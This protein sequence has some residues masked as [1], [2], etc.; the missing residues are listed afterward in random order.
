MTEPPETAAA[1]LSQLASYDAELRHKAARGV[2]D[3]GDAVLQEAIID[4]LG[5]MLEGEPAWRAADS[6]GAIGGTRAAARLVAA[7]RRPESRCEAAV[8][9]S[10]VDYGLP[11]AKDC[12]AAALDAEEAGL[13]ALAATLTGRLSGDPEISLVAKAMRDS[14]WRVRDA[15]LTEGR[16]PADPRLVAPLIGIVTD[17]P[18]DRYEQIYV[19]RHRA[20]SAGVELLQR[21]LREHAPEIAGADL[22]ALT[23]L[24]DP[25]VYEE[26]DEVF[27]E[28][29][30]GA[31]I[32][33]RARREIER[34]S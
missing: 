11:D 33:R 4:A 28:R 3:S 32:R 31:G 24:A 1:L 18:A 19:H 12:L 21:I 27:Q 22:R 2:A 13:R 7:F 20:V 34:R 10:L 23:E 15:V 5:L 9:V 17:H 26:E 30:L 16:P 6:L 8:L 14:S 29:R 25:I